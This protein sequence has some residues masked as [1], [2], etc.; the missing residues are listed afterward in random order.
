MDHISPVNPK[1]GTDELVAA[2]EEIE[3]ARELVDSALNRIHVAEPGSHAS[4]YVS[5]AYAQLTLADTSI[6]N[7]LKIRGVTRKDQTER[8]GERQ[9]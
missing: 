3:E 8:I 9:G 5:T 4:R 2:A 7:E 6:N 1:V